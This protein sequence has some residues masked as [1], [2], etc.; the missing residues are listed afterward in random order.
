MTN[1]NRQ[2]EQTSN[3]FLKTFG[4]INT[5]NRKTINWEKHTEKL[6]EDVFKTTD[7]NSLIN[8]VGNRPI[9]P[10][11]VKSIKKSILENG[12]VLQKGEVGKIKNDGTL[13]VINGQHRVD[14]CIQLEDEG[15]GVF[16]FSYNI[17]EEEFESRDDLISYIQEINSKLYKWNAEDHLDSRCL[18]HKDK[19]SHIRLRQILNIFDSKCDNMGMSIVL[20][21][22]SHYEGA[23]AKMS[24]TKFMSDADIFKFSEQAYDLSRGLLVRLNK[25][26]LHFSRCAKNLRKDKSIF[27]H[28]YFIRAL[29]N[30]LKWGVNDYG[31]KFTFS[32][33]D[34]QFEKY[35]HLYKHQ[36]NNDSAMLQSIL[37]IYNKGK[38]HKNRI[39]YVDVITNR[40]LSKT[41]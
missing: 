38:I 36:G 3:G 27:K 34:S 33:L 39:E 26:S 22:A 28:E 18:V 11:N 20:M 1:T 25:S 37:D 6:S 5:K 16:P 9:K 17:K 40:K 29:L 21:I 12:G 35:S 19:D 2:T 30:A 13:Y 41:K 7:F 8:I 32:E 23:T 15:K 4:I 31:C 14:A 24:T 10:A